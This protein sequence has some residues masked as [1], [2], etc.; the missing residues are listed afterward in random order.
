MRPLLQLLLLFA[1]AAAFV[2]AAP[3]RSCSVQFTSY[4]ALHATPLGS[5]DSAAAAA[6]SLAGDV[7]AKNQGS[8][9]AAAA[10]IAGTTIGGTAQHLNFFA[11]FHRQPLSHFALELF[12]CRRLLGPTLLHDVTWPGSQQLHPCWQLGVPA[13][14][15]FHAD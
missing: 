6:E 3:Q 9:I 14:H 2:P 5:T 7:P 10:L 8:V 13:G 1:A 4:K 11:C 12:V 15:F